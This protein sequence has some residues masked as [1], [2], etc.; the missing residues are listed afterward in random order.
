MGVVAQ[1]RP[2]DD[3]PLAEVRAHMYYVY[4]LKSSKNGKIY[5]GKTDKLP[6]K[7]LAEH[8][9]G[10]NKWTKNNRPFKLIYYEQYFCPEDATK[11]EQFYKMGFGK[12]I[13]KLIVENLDK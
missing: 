1:F 10:S 8:N 13:K 6:E 4:F 9:F 5:C 12:K 7:R 11:R 3:R 2:E